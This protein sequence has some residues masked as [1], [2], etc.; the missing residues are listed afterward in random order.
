MKRLAGL[1]LVYCLLLASAP[2]HAGPLDQPSRLS[3][4]TS[5]RAAS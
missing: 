3:A 5:A 1:V 2:A 4:W